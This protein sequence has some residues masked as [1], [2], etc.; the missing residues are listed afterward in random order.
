MLLND[1]NEYF[2]LKNCKK[3]KLIKFIFDSLKSQKCKD[4]VGNFTEEQAE[5]VELNPLITNA[6]SRIIEHYCQVSL[7]ID[8]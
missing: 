5:Q 2:N 3:K 1:D 6:C 4:V 8:N 7:I